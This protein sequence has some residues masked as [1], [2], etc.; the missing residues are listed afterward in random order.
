MSRKAFVATV[1][2]ADSDM[3]D[4]NECKG[5]ANV[6]GTRESGAPYVWIGPKERGTYRA[7]IDT[8]SM[9]AL[10]KAWIALRKARK[11]WKS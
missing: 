7:I 6:T 4:I 3:P 10:C 1:N 5:L 11:E 2:L 9:D 8:R